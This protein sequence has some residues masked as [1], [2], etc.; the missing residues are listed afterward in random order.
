MFDAI[1]KIAERMTDEDRRLLA[2]IREPRVVSPAESP[3]YISLTV[4]PDGELRCYGNY[5]EN[6]R[7]ADPG[8]IPT[9]LASAD[10]GLTWKRHLNPAGLKACVQSPYSNRRIAYKDW[11][12]LHLYDGR[13]DETAPT[14]VALPHFLFGKLPLALRQRKRWLL[15]GNNGTGDRNT[16]SVFRSDD[17]GETWQESTVPPAPAFTVE[18]PHAGP[19]WGNNGIEPTVTECADGTLLMLLRTSTDYHYLSRSAD[20]GET[21]SVPERTP[22]HSTLTNPEFL[23]LHDGRLLLFF[24][25]TRMLPEVNTPDY[26]P[27]LTEDELTGY[28]EDVFTNRDVLHAAISEDDGKTWRGIREL[29]LNPYRNSADFRTVGGFGGCHDKSC[30]QVQ[31][32]E[33][34]QGKVLVH[35]GQQEYLEKLIIFDPDWLYDTERREDFQRGLEYVSTHVFVKSIS[36][37]FRR[38]YTGHVAWNRTDGALLVP[39]PSGDRS[40]AL[41]LR[42]TED[43]WLYNHRQGVVWNFPAAQKGEVHIRLMRLGQGVRISLLDH[44]INPCDP[45]TE[46]YAC[47]T[48]VLGD[49][50]PG[51]VWADVTVIFDTQ[52]R[53]ATLAVGDE[54]VSLPMN[55][56]AAYG[57]NYLHLQTA[58]DSGDAQGVLVKGF[59]ESAR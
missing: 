44:W 36:G 17:D 52:S 14:V 28:W 51:Q 50:L 11:Q 25:N 40:E 18:P 46:R 23:R 43:E 34:P 29:Y 38:P 55:G 6:V 33:L 5:P 15:F 26:W 35:C 12:S 31:A 47:F 22:L 4:M 53:T 56:E 9:Y 13:E 24:C 42:N 27:P 19:R 2:L 48:A 1:K 37:S 30:H 7:Q 20:G 41:L 57:L 3:A 59:S 39:D 16:T 21:W 54:A 58:A 10:G 49:I 8:R 45:E 32:L